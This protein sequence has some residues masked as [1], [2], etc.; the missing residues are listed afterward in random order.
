MTWLQTREK[1]RLR[2]LREAL[3]PD[4]RTLLVLRVDRDMPWSDV[5]RVFLGDGARGDEASVARKAAALRKR[6]ERVKAMLRERM[7]AAREG[8]E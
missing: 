3:D 4:D 8:S 5:A 1:D 6:F 2:A 7:R